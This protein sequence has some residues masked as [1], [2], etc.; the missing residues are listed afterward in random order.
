MPRAPLRDD[1]AVRRYLQRHIEPG[2]PPCSAG[3]GPWQHVVVVP[4]YRESSELVARL[5]QLPPGHGRT[6]VTLV[7]N[8]PHTDTN[9]AANDTLR[10]ALRELPR[11]PGYHPDC[12][13]HRAS[14]QTDIAVLDL[15]SQR[16][17]LPAREGVGLARKIGF[18]LALLWMQAGKIF[19]DWICSTDA[20]AT[21]PPCY[22]TQLAGAPEGAVGATFPFTHESC[23]DTA[24]SAAGSLY[25]LR[26]HYYVCGLEYA[27]SPYAWHSLG[28]CLAVRKSAYAHVRGWPRR[29]AAE[30]FYLLNKLTKL[31]DI[32]RLQG[33]CIKLATRAS[34]RVPFGTGPAVST[35]ALA[36]T[37]DAAR[38][39]EHPMAFEALRVFLRV[40]PGLRPEHGCDVQRQLLSGGLPEPLAREAART[41]ENLKFARALEH[42]REYSKDTQSFRQHF[43]QWFDAF[44]TLRFLRELA[45]AGWENIALDELDSLQPSLWPEHIAG[46]PDALR[47]ALMQHWDWD[48]LAGYGPA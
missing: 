5:A 7:I 22:F 23:H 48:P 21:L 46:D 10:E 6:L 16:G 9:A 39:F 35:M 36:A 43:N 3:A 41:L 38:V 47:R 37:P 12:A 26:L 19:D 25:E 17:P 29:A 1:I 15:D 30:D 8:R 11:A 33:A 31:G 34:D 40:L 44:R 24:L 14:A 2:L 13:L 32:A 20:D 4:A 27:R 18:D 28:S 42:C 45:R